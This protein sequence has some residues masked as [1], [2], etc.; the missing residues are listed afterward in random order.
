M[1]HVT[2]WLMHN[3]PFWNATGGRNHI[4]WATNDRGTCSLQYAPLE[5]QHSIKVVG[6]VVRR[7]AAAPGCGWCWCAC[8]GGLRGRGRRAE[9][10]C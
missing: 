1:M 6:M 4:M 10:S 2:H 8:E 5:M 7:T 3:S 9:S